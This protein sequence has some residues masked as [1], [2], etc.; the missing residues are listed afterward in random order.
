MEVYLSSPC[1]PLWYGLGEFVITFCELHLVTGLKA[2]YFD[3]IWS[4]GLELCG[5]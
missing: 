1:I 2:G 3:G 4:V 5:F